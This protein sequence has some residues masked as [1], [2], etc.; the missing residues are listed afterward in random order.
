MQVLIRASVRARS[1]SVW[2]DFRSDGSVRQLGGDDVA[3]F[4]LRGIG[5]C[6]SIDARDAEAAAQDVVGLCHLQGALGQGEVA[7]VV[8]GTLLDPKGDALL[9]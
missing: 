8:V 5:E 6:M 3:R 9:Q 4:E 7:P 1:E 2:S